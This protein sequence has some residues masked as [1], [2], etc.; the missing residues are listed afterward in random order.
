MD[1]RRCLE[2][3]L[4]RTA[5]A[6]LAASLAGC[7]ARPPEGPFAPPPIA[8]AERH[9]F[10][11]PLSGPKPGDPAGLEREACFFLRLEV[12]A[13]ETLPAGALVALEAVTRTRVA[14]GAGRPIQ[15]TPRLSRG[16]RVDV[17]TG[18]RGALAD[19]LERGVLPRRWTLAASSLGAL[20]PG[21]TWAVRVPLANPAER[22]GTFEALEVEAYRLPPG[23][24]GSEAPPVRVAIAREGAFVPES[25]EDGGPQGASEK[26]AALP[27][28]RAPLALREISILEAALEDRRASAV[29]I[30][31]ATPGAPFGAVAFALEVERLPGSVDPHSEEDAAALAR[32][33]QALEAAAEARV[34]PEDLGLSRED[35]PQRLRQVAK[36]LGDPKRRRRVLAH[37]AQETGAA[38]AG[39]LAVSASDRDIALVAEKVAAAFESAEEAPDLAALGWIVERSALEAAETLVDEESGESEVAGILALHLGQVGRQVAAIERVLKR[40]RD[41][42]SF[43]RRLVEENYAFLEDNLPQA[44]ARSLEWLAA[45]GL[46]PAGYDPLAP[47]RE[48]RAALEKAALDSER[49]PAPKEENA[50]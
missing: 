17:G 48:R 31:P 19:L 39:D 28:P 37:L 20:P 30:V 49:P 50:P 46:A 12:F 15:P 14:S 13:L 41:L 5:A 34:T 24:D 40:S 33:A 4:R 35:L 6:A 18:A 11:T 36:V 38:L 3:T 47:P 25:A 7:A 22:G 43:A 9:F 27:P 1:P 23:D 10:G 42:A 21:V 2:K 44:R 16:I 45:R 26:D 32:L 29:G 8:L